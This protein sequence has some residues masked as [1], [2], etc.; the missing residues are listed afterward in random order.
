MLSKTMRIKI[1]GGCCTGSDGGHKV[2][3]NRNVIVKT[4]YAQFMKLK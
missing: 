4:I 1:G 2:H 3:I